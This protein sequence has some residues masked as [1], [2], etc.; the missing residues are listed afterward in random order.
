MIDW[1]ASGASSLPE[2]YD[3]GLEL[4]EEIAQSLREYLLSD[5]RGDDADDV[6]RTLGL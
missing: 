4:R 2:D 1:I 3:E 6:F 5:R